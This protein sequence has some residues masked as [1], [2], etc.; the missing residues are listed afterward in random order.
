M[1]LRA[2]RTNCKDA[3]SFDWLIWKTYRYL[4]VNRQILRMRTHEYGDFTHKTHEQ[5]RLRSPIIAAVVHFSL[6]S[7]YIYFERCYD[8]H[9]ISRVSHKEM[10][11]YKFKFLPWKAQRFTFIGYE[12]FRYPM[13]GNW[14][15]VLEIILDIAAS[16]IR[17]ERGLCGD[18]IE[19][20][21]NILRSYTYQLHK[22]K[23][24]E[25]WELYILF[26]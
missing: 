5:L 4:D 17:S 26:S 6:P 11:S 7:F 16:W 14:L 10:H 25:E 12:R 8:V 3:I 19:I 18:I 20:W 2:I 21:N 13:T 1:A 23:C 15:E 9:P 22:F 24:R